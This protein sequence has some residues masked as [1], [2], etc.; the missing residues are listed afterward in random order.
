MTLTA[1]LTKVHAIGAAVYDLDAI[2]P[3][4][5][6]LQA[7]QQI[8]AGVAGTAPLPPTAHMTWR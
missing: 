7:A 3:T 8:C 4:P 2:P 1:P 6:P 5:I